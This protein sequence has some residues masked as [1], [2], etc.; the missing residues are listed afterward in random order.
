M[1]DVFQIPSQ[2]QTSPGTGGDFD[3]YTAPG[4]ARP[5]PLSR[6][7]IVPEGAPAKPIW[8]VT[9]TDLMGLILTF[10][11]LLFTMSENAVHQNKSEIADDQFE[12]YV[13]QSSQLVGNTKETGVVDQVELNRIDYNKAL[14][15]GYLRD[16]LGTVLKET[17]ALSRANLFEDKEGGRLIVTL[18]QDLLFAKGEAKIG[19]TGGAA[20]KPLTALL[21]NIRNGVEIVGHADPSQSRVGA[22]AT[23]WSLSLNRAMAVAAVMRGEGYTRPLPVMGD[24]S[25]LYSYLP[26]TLPEAE[27]ERLSRRVDIIINSHDNSPQQRYGIGR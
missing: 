18:P 4:P 5:I 6:K 15:L 13:K 21:R 27:R 17:P 25:S 26:A 10:F 2:G 7:A 20:L 11:V 3:D 14:D 8:V 23:N 9:I 16:L 12:E 19:E 22:A 1:S 24:S